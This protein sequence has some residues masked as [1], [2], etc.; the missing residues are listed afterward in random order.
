MTDVTFDASLMRSGA[1]NRRPPAARRF[2]TWTV[3]LTTGLPLLLVASALIA[4]AAANR[5]SPWPTATIVCDALA[6]FAS[7]LAALRL[8]AV[9]RAAYLALSRAHEDLQRRVRAATAVFEPER[10]GV[11]MHDA[12]HRDL[13]SLLAQIDAACCAIGPAA[14]RDDS[15]AVHRAH[16]YL[17]EAHVSTLHILRDVRSAVRC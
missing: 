12:L 1:G 6:T 7:L 11:D 13:A 14:A 5:A 9:A 2:P 10:H 15:A 17:S 3:L 8:A 4:Q 16:A